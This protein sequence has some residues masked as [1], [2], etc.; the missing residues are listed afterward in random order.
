MCETDADSF[1]LIIP[2][3]TGSFETFPKIL[4]K[5]FRCTSED[6]K[7]NE[8]NKPY[9]KY[10]KTQLITVLIVSLSIACILEEKD[11][12]LKA[13]FASPVAAGG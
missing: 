6:F 8:C 10:T 11:L 5:K 3:L 2:L 9:C 1:A 7:N 13:T 4:S 12:D